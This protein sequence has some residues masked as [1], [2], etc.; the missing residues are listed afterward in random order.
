[1]FSRQAGANIDHLKVIRVGN[2]E[3]IDNPL[4]DTFFFFCAITEDKVQCYLTFQVRVLKRRIVGETSLQTG[5]GPSSKQ[6]S[7]APQLGGQRKGKPRQWGFL[8]KYL[9]PPN[10][11]LRKKL[12]VSASFRS[13]LKHV[14]HKLRRAGGRG[15]N[16][17]PFYGSPGSSHFRAHRLSLLL[18]GTSFPVGQG[19][20]LSKRSPSAITTPWPGSGEVSGVENPSWCLEVGRETGRR[21]Q[22]QGRDVDRRGREPCA[23]GG[24]GDL[25]GLEHKNARTHKWTCSA[26]KM[27]PPRDAAK[28]AQG[29]VSLLRRAVPLFIGLSD[30]GKN[31]PGGARNPK[32]KRGNQFDEMFTYANL[33]GASGEEPLGFC[34]AT[35]PI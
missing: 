29:S 19:G 20:R 30:P 7:I 8:L 11:F 24:S 33:A 21:H 17:L 14:P 26:R 15:G 12:Q 16:C 28:A 25:E 13:F 4:Q 35:P 3:G 27:L 32:S 2:K 34:K 10:T 22:P 9:S 1:M 31:L 18:Q 23:A 5:E 6:K